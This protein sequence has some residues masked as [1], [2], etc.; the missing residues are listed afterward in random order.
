MEANHG[1]AAASSQIRGRQ[2][3]CFNQKSIRVNIWERDKKPRALEC[4]HDADVLAAGSEIQLRKSNKWCGD[5]ATI[6]N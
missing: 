2:K 6:G 5:L 4:W 3:H 1:R